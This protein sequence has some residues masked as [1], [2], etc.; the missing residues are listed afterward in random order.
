VT[1]EEPS[2]DDDVKST[3][4]KKNHLIS[5]K[6]IRDFIKAHPGSQKDADTFRRWCKTLELAAWLKSSDIKAT[7][8]SAEHVGPLVVFNVGGGKYRVV[9][10]IKFKKNKAAWVYIKHVLTHPEYDDEQWKNS[11]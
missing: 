9:A 8:M 7:F 4:S 2:D 5:R 10:S 6:K 1:K 11:T 3:K